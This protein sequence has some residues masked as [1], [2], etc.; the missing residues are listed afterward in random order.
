MTCTKI[1]GST[2][3]ICV[4]NNDICG[5]GQCYASFDANLTNGVYYGSGNINGG[6]NN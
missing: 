3:A 5:K 2:L 4:S 6:F 1:F